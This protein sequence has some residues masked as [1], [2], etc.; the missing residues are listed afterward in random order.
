MRIYS[1]AGWALAS[2]SMATSS[3]RSGFLAVV[4]LTMVLGLT[5]SYPQM[6]APPTLMS[7]SLSQ[8]PAVSES[9]RKAASA[10]Q[11]VSTR[12]NSGRAAGAAGAAV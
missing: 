4:R 10:N 11:L 8:K 12:P 2:T 7:Y 6:S 5:P 1:L 3:P 9:P